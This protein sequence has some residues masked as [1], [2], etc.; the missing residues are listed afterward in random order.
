MGVLEQVTEMKNQGI[1]EDE[2][3]NKLQEQGISPRAINEALGQSNIK[4]AVSGEREEDIEPSIRGETPPEPPATKQTYMP[5]SQEIPE[6]HE[7]ETYL[8]AT[9]EAYYPPQEGD[10][11]QEEFGGYGEY[12]GYGAGADTDR[13]I[14]IA[15]QVFSEKIKEIQKQ[16]ENVT[17][18]KS[19][20][21]I[22]LDHA[23]E[24][25][26]KIEATM[27]RLQ[28]AI[29]EKIGS[30]GRTLE[31][32]KKEMSMMQGSFGKMVGKVAAKHHAP[33]HKR[34][35]PRKPIARKKIRKKK[36]TVSRR[37]R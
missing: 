3:V 27:D 24:R 15:E 9:Q 36:K 20:A 35:A 32:I 23:T 37:K 30:Y 10:Y 26:K 6:Q 28:M 22:K 4:T 34:P 13:F 19:L 5:S 17:E 21:Q 31:S 7:A 33:I 25:I 11:P 12:G 18:F 29:L 8:P 2:I 1:P 16:L 14:E